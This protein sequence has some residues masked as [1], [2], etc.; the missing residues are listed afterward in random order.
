MALSRDEMIAQIL[1]KQKAEKQIAPGPTRDEMIAH[2][3]ANQKT[4]P[5]PTAGDNARAALQSLGEQASYDY[6]PKMQAAVSSILPNPNADLDE[7][8]KAQGFKVIQ[9]KP[10][11]ESEKRGFKQ[12]SEDVARKAPVASALG[13]IGGALL[14]AGLPAGILGK[15][16]KVGKAVFGGPA[17][18]LLA[19]AG[20][21]AASGAL[22]GAIQDTEG[23]RG[24]NAVGAAELGAGIETG[25]GMLG[26]TGRAIGRVGPGL[27]KFANNRALA[28]VG[29]FNKD[30]ARLAK[31][32]TIGNIGKT[33]Q[34][35]GDF[36]L[37]EGLVKA[38]DSIDDIAQ[39]IGSK[40]EEIGKRIGA[41]YKDA[42][43]P[44]F[45]AEAM[46]LEYLDRAQKRLR[47][48]PGGDKALAAVEREV[49]NLA[50]NGN[51]AS[52]ETINNFRK[53]V[54]DLI[55][56]D[57]GVQLMSIP[58][59]EALLDLRRFIAAKV[60]RGFGAVESPAARKELKALNSQ[61]GKL[62]DLDRVARGRVVSE[63][64]NN[65][66][67][68][69]DKMALLGGAGVGAGSAMGDGGDAGSMIER[70]AIG[71]GA[72]LLSK[73]ARSYGR[74]LIMKGADVAG[75]GMLGV[76]N[77][78]T[79][80]AKALTPKSAQEFAQAVSKLGLTDPAQ[81][82]AYAARYKNAR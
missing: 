54:D 27:K 14:T 25:L 16:G 40:R 28:A 73:G 31:K 58:E 43:A 64:G 10:T 74:P 33:A 49:E 19:R 9:D 26:K 20:Q 13:G 78:V 56:H 38:G 82:G 75:R 44:G 4:A 71:A 24:D 61:Y 62:S 36:V 3:L 11:Y 34:G 48:K 60:Q 67:S 2:I 23:N 46:G 79:D 1:A 53:G 39:R 30:T 69:T 5:E 55:P 32:D 80:A 41:A 17:K 29:A 52:L 59:K 45:D 66:L 63:T 70:A 51:N 35:L 72:G 57:K 15:A 77:A 21:A 65:L 18:S 76:Q 8:Q 42:A 47:G 50:Q 7:Q 12:Y 22:T 6:L 68:L 81:I 37:Q